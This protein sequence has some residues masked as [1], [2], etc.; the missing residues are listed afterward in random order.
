MKNKLIYKINL[1]Y[2][3]LLEFYFKVFFNFILKCFFENMNYR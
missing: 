1:N 2:H 3:K